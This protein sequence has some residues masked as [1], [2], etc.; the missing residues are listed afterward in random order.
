[1]TNR[2]YGD[3]MTTLSPLASLLRTYAYA[4]TASHDFDVCERIMVD[5][6]E[7]IMNTFTIAGRDEQ[8]KPA[9]A[10]QY[11]QF[12]GLGFTVHRFVSN[13][14][15]AAL[16]FTEHGTS[17]LSGTAASWQGV[18]LYRWDHE[19]LTQCRVEQDYFSRT[20]Q[21]DAGAPL[22][23]LPP[24]LDPF[25]GPDVAESPELEAVV[26]TWLESGRWLEDRAVLW[27]DARD[28][29]APR[30]V[31][32]EATSTVLDL[33]TAGDHAAFHVRAAGTYAGGLGKRHD[34]LLGR[35]AD[36][37]ATGMVRLDNG[38]P[39]GHVVT[40]RLTSLRRLQAE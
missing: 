20:E 5:D 4:Y 12:P 21:Q 35:A 7:L 34:H 23:V 18:S 32:D 19:R 3:S 17:V 11:A 37:F 36:L 28:A 31:L 8:Y 15:R 22:P 38:Q 16:H 6:Y 13:G 29:Y 33:F 40:D 2:L 26:R 27:D 30:F 39:T 25:L 1:M 9:T 14:E 24:A 10:K